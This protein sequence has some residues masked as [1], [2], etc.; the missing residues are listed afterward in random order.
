MGES[1]EL[2][3]LM[4]FAPAGFVSSLVAVF[5]RVIYTFE[6]LLD[7]RD[8]DVEAMIAVSEPQTAAWWQKKALAWQE[9]YAVAYD[10]STGVFKYSVEDADSRIIKFAAVVDQLPVTIKLAAADGNGLPTSLSEDQLLMVSTY[11][12]KIKVPG[13]GIAVVSEQADTLLISSSTIHFDAQVDLITLKDNIE[14]AINNYLRNL[15]FNG[16]LSKDDLERHIQQVA[17]VLEV[18]M[19]VQAWAG[20]DQP[21]TVNLTY[22]PLA[23][24][25]VLDQNSAIYDDSN[26]VAK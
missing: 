19:V 23:G 22:I 3:P 14:A 24:Y 20:T 18:E 11:L 15:P 21:T 12:H 26:Y 17:G 9:G 2:S 13:V 16:E 1:G 7:S 10:A 4:P 6:L 5:A 8:S 25:F